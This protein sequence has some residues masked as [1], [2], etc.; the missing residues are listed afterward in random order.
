MLAYVTLGSNDTKKALEFYDAVLGEVGTVKF[1]VLV[2]NDAFSKS[3]EM[4]HVQR[5]I[6]STVFG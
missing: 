3:R 6:T 2:E 5:G 4:S 1:D